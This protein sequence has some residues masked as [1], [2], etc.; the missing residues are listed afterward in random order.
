ML[1]APGLAPRSLTQRPTRAH[2]LWPLG[3]PAA[4]FHSFRAAATAAFGSDTIPMPNYN[5]LEVGGW[6]KSRTGCLFCFPGHWSPRV[7]TEPIQNPFFCR[8]I[9]FFIP[10]DLFKTVPGCAPPPLLNHFTLNLSRL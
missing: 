10:P 2:A 4:C 8:F 7:H 9:L 3:E 1:P 6:G 5:Q